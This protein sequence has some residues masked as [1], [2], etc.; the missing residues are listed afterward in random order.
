[1]GVGADPLYWGPLLSTVAGGGISIRVLV[2]HHLDSAKLPGC[3]VAPPIRAAGHGAL[4]FAA[5]CREIFANQ[6]VCV[7][8]E[9]G[10]TSVLA[11]ALCRAFGNR[12]TLLLVENHP[13]YLLRNGIRRRGLFLV[14]RYLLA[15]SVDS[16]LTNNC[17]GAAYVG[18]TLRVRPARI[19]VGP[20]LTSVLPSSEWQHSSLQHTPQIRPGALKIAAVGRLIEKK[21]FHVLIRE[22]A[23]LPDS[24]ITRLR[25]SIFG[26]GHERNALQEQIS[27]LGLSDCITL[28]GGVPYAALGD[29]LKGFDCFVMPTLADYRSLSSFEALALGLPL[30]MSVHDGA[31]NEVLEEGVNGFAFDPDRCGDLALAIVRLCQAVDDGQQLSRESS[32]I[33]SQF[34]V[35]RAAKVL[36][37]AIRHAA[38]IRG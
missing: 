18:V 28:E 14:A 13:K 30:L 27:R 31:I 37:D 33:A 32:R 7:V 19:I 22:I 29:R 2:G 11:V 4:R 20:Y 15:Q 12:P 5:F 36:S 38:R 1:M 16:V 23:S 3:T 8:N 24:L 35:E 26:D 17:E 25:V 34:T 10:L 9:F 6:G 21:G